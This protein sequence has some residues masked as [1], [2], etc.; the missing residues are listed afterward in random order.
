MVV[1]RGG[2]VTTPSLRA[3]PEPTLEYRVAEDMEGGTYANAVTIWH[4]GHEFTFDFGSSLPPSQTE[5]GEVTVPFRV[6]ARVKL[7]VSVIFDLLQAINS[8]MTAYEETFG[9][10]SGMSDSADDDG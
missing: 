7:P 4:T 3:M 1:T 10:I 9:P 5:D 8:N 2:G 6:V